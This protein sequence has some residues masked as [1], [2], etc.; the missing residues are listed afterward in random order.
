[1]LLAACCVTDATVYL[2]AHTTGV[3]AARVVELL[4]VP[5]REEIVRIDGDRV[6]FAHPFLARGSYT[7]AGPARRRRMHRAVA[8][9]EARP[10]LRARHMAL[11][12]A[13]ADP[14][15]WRR[16]TPPRTPRRCGGRRLPPPISTN[17]PSVSAETLRPVASALPNNTSGHVTSTRL[18]LSWSP[19][20]TSWVPALR[21][22]RRVF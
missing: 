1:M 22:R 14:R 13:T 9:V 3:S 10:E 20:S 7:D 17:W 18:E 6:L 4:E 16:S 19:R 12:A 15:R 11:G 5:E 2:L 8:A 21:A